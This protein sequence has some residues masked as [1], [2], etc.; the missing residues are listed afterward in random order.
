MAAFIDPQHG[1]CDDL[2]PPEWEHK[3]T[4][5]YIFEPSDGLYHLFY[6]G[7]DGTVQEATSPDFRLGQWTK[8][9]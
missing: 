1:L 4:P 5:T 3:P 9:D 7:E 6:E 2:M 8:V